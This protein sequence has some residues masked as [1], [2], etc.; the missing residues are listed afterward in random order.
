V[1]ELLD[2][3]PTHACFWFSPAVFFHMAHERAQPMM[4]EPH[5]ETHLAL[6]QV[7]HLQIASVDAGG[8]QQPPLAPKVLVSVV[9]AN[10][11]MHELGFVAP[12]QPNSTN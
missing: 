12:P 8:M 4:D 11:D 9:H 7:L 1:L 2:S 10:K 3:C 5:C 6:P